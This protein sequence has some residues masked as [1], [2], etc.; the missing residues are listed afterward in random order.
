MYTS[1]VAIQ[2]IYL[3][4]NLMCDVGVVV[5]VVAHHTHPGR[6]RTGTSLFRLNIEVPRTYL[7]KGRKI[8]LIQR[9]FVPH[10][11]IQWILCR[12][13]PKRQVIS[14]PGIEL[15]STPNQRVEAVLLGAN[16]KYLRTKTQCGV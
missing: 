6:Q 10:R 15:Q 7:A 11:Q 8:P 13:L 2:H 9:S 5:W 12:D 14:F 3:E 4:A 16:F 1:T